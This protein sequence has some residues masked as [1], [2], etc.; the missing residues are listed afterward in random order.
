[1]VGVENIA[2][3]ELYAGK[4]TFKIPRLESFSVGDFN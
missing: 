1:M 3:F 2:S 4:K